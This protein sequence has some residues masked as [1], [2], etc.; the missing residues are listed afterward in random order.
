MP[1]YSIPG[2]PAPTLKINPPKMAYT[3]L[4]TPFPSLATTSSQGGFIASPMPPLAFEEVIE[5]ETIEGEI[6]IKTFEELPIFT[7]GT[8]NVE[9]VIASEEFL[10]RDIGFIEE[11][12]LPP[13]AIIERDTTLPSVA[14]VTSEDISNLPNRGDYSSRA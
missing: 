13:V 8:K 7:C 1:L 5:I 11:D 14:I 9:Q 6:I 12:L 10:V 3:S 2:L 4:K